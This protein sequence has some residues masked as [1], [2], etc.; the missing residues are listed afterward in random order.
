M[1]MAS[2]QTIDSGASSLRRLP[3]SWITLSLFAV[4]IAYVDGFWVIS[5]RGAIGAIERTQEPFQMWLRESTI[6]LP[7]MFVAVFVIMAWTRRWMGQTEH[8][9]AKFA[10]TALLIVVVTTGIS[11]AQSSVNAAY[12]YHLQTNLLNVMHAAHSHD[13]VYTTPSGVTTAI[14]SVKCDALCIAK[15]ETLHAQFR[16]I[17]AVSIKLILTNLVLV[18]WILALRGG[19]LWVPS[20]LKR[21]RADKD[22]VGHAPAGA[23]LA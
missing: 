6:M 15:N 16:G 4:L 14:G 2:P 10:T 9:F 22:P 23:V 19:Q 20:R 11:I 8:K 18:V 17:K 3:V 13:T 5:L 12:D 1:K 21:E 7:I